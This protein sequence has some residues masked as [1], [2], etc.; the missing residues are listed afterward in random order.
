MIL[1]DT[2][3]VHASPPDV[4]AFFE[5][6]DHERYLDWHPDHKVFRWTRGHGVKVGHEFYFEEVIAGKL[7]K[8]HVVFTRIDD[9]AHIEFAPTCRLMRLFLPRLVF[10]LEKI[11]DR[12]YRVI[13]EIVLRIGPLAAR[14]NRRE[15]DAVREH[16]RV[17]GINLKRF[18]ESRRRPACSPGRRWR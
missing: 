11:A 3:E 17:E 6:M 7:L 14:L 9:G 5:D 16:M 12:H 10:R 18:V 13:A 2:V 4:F 8:K 15:L 1:R